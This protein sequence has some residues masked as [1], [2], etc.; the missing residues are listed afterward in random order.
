MT[1]DSSRRDFLI[2]LS[3]AW[4]G[5]ACATDPSS[6]EGSARLSARPGT[7][8]G[9]L[10]PGITALGLDDARDGFLLAPADYDPG[11]PWPLVLALHGA[12]ITHTGPLNFLGP[13]AESRG[14]LLLAVD[15]ADYTWDAIRGQYGPD[16]A[17]IDRALVAAFDRALVDPAHLIVEGFSDG[18]S[19][20]LGLARA[21]GDLFTRAVAFSP[22]FVPRSNTPD[23]GRPAIF[24]SHGRQDPVLPID[25]TSRRIVPAL[26]ADGYDVEYLEYDG[27]HSVTPEVAAAAVEW[28][29]R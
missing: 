23:A 13:Y 8:T 1:A 6:G 27:V 14:F 20:A 21:N 10:A 18:A 17:F 28:M 29:L 9:T 5:L 22:G 3:T 12:G 15:S 24:I 25:E 4:I 16:V 11:R 19:Y 7:P 26:R 2:T